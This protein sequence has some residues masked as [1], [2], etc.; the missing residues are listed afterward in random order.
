MLFPG[1]YFYTLKHFKGIDIQYAYICNESV[2]I[3]E[4]VKSLHF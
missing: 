1:M 3:Q 4:H 2:V